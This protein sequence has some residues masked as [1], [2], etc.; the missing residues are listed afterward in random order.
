MVMVLRLAWAIAALIWSTVANATEPVRQIGIYVQPYYEAARTPGG[1]P[2]V[3]VGKQ[4]DDLLSSNRREDIL[5]ARDLVLAKPTLVSPMTMMVLAIRLYD[6]RR[7]G[8]LVL[9]RQR[10]VYRDV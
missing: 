6:T 2:Q 5:A 3:A 10:A 7:R 8:V 4:Y 9:R 1:K